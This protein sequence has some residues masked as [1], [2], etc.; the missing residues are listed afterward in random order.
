MTSKAA[1]TITNRGPTIRGDQG[2]SRVASTREPLGRTTAHCAFR[3]SL[4]GTWL[5]ASFTIAI[6]LH[7]KTTWDAALFG[8]VLSLKAYVRN[9]SHK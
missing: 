3:E 7:K 1:M 2:P 4:P 9:T 6:L 8:A 5:Y